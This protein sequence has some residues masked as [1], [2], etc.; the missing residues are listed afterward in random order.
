MKHAVIRH[1][2]HASLIAIIFAA[3]AGT[4]GMVVDG[5]VIG[6]YLGDDAM[7]AFGLASP[8]FLLI[9]A[10]GSIFAAGM[11]AISA[12]RIG[13]GDIP[14]ANRSFSLSC[15]MTALI[16]ILFMLIIGIFSRQISGFLGASGGAA[17]LSE[18]T[19]SYLIG[20]LPG[21]PVFMFQFVLQPVLQ[22]D[23]DRLRI[24]AATVVMTVVDIAG[25]F[26]VA[27]VLHGGMFGM[28]MATSVSYIASM[29]VYLMHFARKNCMF[30]FSLRRIDFSE[31]PEMF[32]S[33]IPTAN[34]RISGTLRTF[35]LN[36]LLLLLS[37][38]LAVTAL[39]AQ[40]N[41]YNIFASIG[42]GLSTSV[43]TLSGIF[44]GERD[45][46]A[47]RVLL[48]TA[49]R[50][51]VLLVGVVAAVLFFG[52]P[53]FAG[54]Y[55]SEASGACF[56]AVRSV[57]MFALS[58]PVHAVS[59]VFAAHLQAT[60]NLK[61]SNLICFLNDF[62]YT[63]L[64]AVIL[65]SIFGTDGVWA[66]FPAGRILLLITLYVMAVK[67]SGH[68]RTQFDDY[69]FLPPGFDPQGHEKL[70]CAVESEEDLTQMT[71]R[72]RKYCAGLNLNAGVPE[73][74]MTVTRRSA[75]HILEQGF[76]RN[77]NKSVD[78]TVFPCDGGIVIRLRDNGRPLEP[79]FFEEISP[80]VKSQY[81]STMGMNNTALQITAP[82]A[83]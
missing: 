33:G 32:L 17:G 57:R 11:Q 31:I 1:A 46:G 42:V 59:N 74:A 69:L 24:F 73:Q 15:V 82:S 43:L 48:G 21:I 28:A 67:Q 19:R 65:G 20:L 10:I 5:I 54:L 81:I 58:L 12:K 38:Q 79:S 53:L 61:L 41:M 39:S 63:V 60:E 3:F 36:R 2:F 23:E 22:M 25:D 35:T 45:R 29:I 78:I 26:F 40:T 47:L 18:D 49:L 16:G 75:E 68:I 72:V 50:Y 27:A 70:V 6:R 37:G 71:E 77:E 44:F 14:G 55:L 52:A 66:A 76:Q 64:C 4:A 8:V 83:D 7:A 62:L 34:S 56:L 80:A 30:R 13:E 9:N 51:A